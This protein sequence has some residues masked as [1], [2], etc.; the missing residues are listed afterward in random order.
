MS[1]Y[2]YVEEQKVVIGNDYIE[3]IFS[4]K[5]NHLTTTEIINKRIDGQKSLKFKNY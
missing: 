2:A 3:R 1:V 4:I 5:D